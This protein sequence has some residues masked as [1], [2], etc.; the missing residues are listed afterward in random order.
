M[1]EKMKPNILP[2]E[3]LAT[4]LV[5][6]DPYVPYTLLDRIASTR[7]F[8]RHITS[9]RSPSERI[10]PG[11]NSQII[12]DLSSELQQTRKQ[13]E[14][15]NRLLS[16]TNDLLL[17]MNSKLEIQESQAYFWTDA[18]IDAERQADEDIKNN[19]IR[20]FNNLDQIIEFLGGSK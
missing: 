12:E 11:I 18:W 8:F 10:Q 17:Q 15:H 19:N 6:D 1:E 13:L 7:S 14:K 5:A 4:Y 2:D 3:L 20:T 9:Q 16:I